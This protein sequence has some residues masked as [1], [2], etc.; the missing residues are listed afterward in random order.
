MRIDLNS[1]LAYW[2]SALLDDAAGRQGELTG[3]S[4]GWIGN[5]F[6]QRCRSAFRTYRFLLLLD[7]R[8]NEAARINETIDGDGGDRRRLRV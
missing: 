1:K 5:A 3:G 8:A 2:Q 7:K 6:F 4:R